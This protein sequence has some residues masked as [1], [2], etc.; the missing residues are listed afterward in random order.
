MKK[1]IGTIALLLA[2]MPLAQAAETVGDKAQEVKQDAVQAKR[3]TGK[4]V[5]KAGRQVKA[6]G[7]KVRQA[8]ITRCADGRHTVKG[9]AGCVG[10]GGVSDPK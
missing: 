3:E 6:T 2:F 9:K 5:R 7:R 8:V 1:I 10:H 4:E